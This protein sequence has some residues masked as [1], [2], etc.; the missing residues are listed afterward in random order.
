MSRPSPFRVGFVTGATPDKWARAWRERRREPLDLVPLLESEQEHGVRD[1]DLDMALVRLPVDRDNLHC[2]GL[3]AEVPVVI[4]GAEH[5]VAV[6]DT[7]ALA[8]LADEQLVRPHASGWR[9]DAEQL[10]WP[11][12]SEKDAIETVAAGTGIVIVPMSIARLH[13]RKDIVQ[14]PVTDLDPTQIALIWLLDR[15]AEDTQ[16]FV[17]VVRGRSANS[18]R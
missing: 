8:D 4:A 18:S 17:G 7:V 13:Q 11:P 6:A 2:I 16:A 12:M 15:D 3:Y 14:R 9:P 1:G 10:D 5:F